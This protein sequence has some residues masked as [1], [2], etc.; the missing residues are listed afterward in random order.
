MTRI[1]EPYE[2]VLYIDEAGDDGLR[3][4][5]PIDE[6]GGSEWLCIGGLL[7]RARYEETTIDWVR[8]IRTD[9][10]AVQ[11]PALHYRNLSPTKRLRACEILATH[12]C[13]FFFGRFE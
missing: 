10:N 1:A 3:R 13:R 12:P 5:Q 6:N 2:Y 4:V 11:G 7:I 8:N 9:I